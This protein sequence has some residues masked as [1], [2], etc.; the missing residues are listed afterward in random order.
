VN[1][2]LFSFGV[3]LTFEKSLD[4]KTVYELDFKLNAL[5]TYQLLYEAKRS[6]RYTQKDK[7]AKKN[8]KVKR[9][10]IFSPDL[11]QIVSCSHEY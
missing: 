1:E 3:I 2:K 9:T 10:I 11:L 5:I 7:L 8:P 4:F 6:S